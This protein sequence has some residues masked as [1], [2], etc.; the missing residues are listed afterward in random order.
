MKKLTRRQKLFL[1]LYP[2]GHCVLVVLVT[3][4]AF[5]SLNMD[6]PPS[7]HDEILRTIFTYATHVLMPSLFLGLGVPDT[8]ALQW[9]LVVLPAMIYACVFLLAYKV[10]RKR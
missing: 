2:V 8:P 4:A 10:I 3:I 6:G 5:A 9:V 1:F 7:R